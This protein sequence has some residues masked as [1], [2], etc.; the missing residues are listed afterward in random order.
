MTLTVFFLT[1]RMLTGVTND[2]FAQGC[3]NAK[4][5]TDKVFLQLTD[6]RSWVA[7]SPPPVDNSEYAL[8]KWL[9]VTTTSHIFSPSNHSKWLCGSKEHHLT[10]FLTHRYFIDFATCHTDY[11]IWYNHIFY[12]RFS[13]IPIVRFVYS[14]HRIADFSV[15]THAMQ[16]FLT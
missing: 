2:G 9:V 13:K 3:Q 5:S 15:A 16:V 10:L 4:A 12:I 6:N 14:Q 7:A 11:V 1:N 8:R